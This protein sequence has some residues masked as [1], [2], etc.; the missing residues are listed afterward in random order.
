MNK[1]D[2]KMMEWDWIPKRTGPSRQGP[3]CLPVARAGFPRRPT[4]RAKERANCTFS[5]CSESGACL[6]QEPGSQEDRPIERKREPT[7]PSLSVPSPVLACRKS[8]VPKKTDRSSERE[9][10]LH[11][12]CLFRVR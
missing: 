7:A 2:L 5:V 6:S 12:L 10:Q 8:R 11:L 4:D 9:S 1:C 3:L